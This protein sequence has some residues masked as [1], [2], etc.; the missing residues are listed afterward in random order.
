MSVQD[1]C[2]QGITGAHS[3]ENKQT[4]THKNNKDEKGWKKMKNDET[5]SFHFIWG[6]TNVI[7][8]VIWGVKKDETR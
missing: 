2:A 6:V 4:K 8:H 1:S 3:R 7:F 5:R